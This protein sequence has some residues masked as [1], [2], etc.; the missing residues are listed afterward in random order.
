VIPTAAGVVTPVGVEQRVERLGEVSAAAAVGVGPAGA[1]V[2]AVVV[3][4]A[5]PD[6]PDRAA[7][8][9]QAVAAAAD[10]LRGRR[11]RLVPADPAL[12]DAVR[13]VAGVEV[14][15]VLVAGALPVDIRHASKVDR[16]AVA[17][18]AARV[19]AGS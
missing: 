18:A 14:A 4:P 19:L 10:R 6:R 3:V 8:G 12:A 2:V 9:R 7:R 15:A 17:R 16:T 5:F 13:K 1:Q 11:G